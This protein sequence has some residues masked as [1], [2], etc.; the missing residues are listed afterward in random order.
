MFCSDKRLVFT[1]TDK[2][3]ELLDE[4][5]SDY[6]TSILASF[7]G[8]LYCIMLHFLHSLKFQFEYAD[9]INFFLL[10]FTLFLILFSVFILKD[11]VIGIFD[12]ARV[13]IYL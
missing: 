5:N 6:A 1:K 2:G 4:L 13:T 12:L 8:L 7:I 9:Y 3:K 10:F 11:L